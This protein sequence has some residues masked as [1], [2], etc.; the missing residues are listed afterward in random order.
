[1][2]DVR[3]RYGRKG[4]LSSEQSA[5]IE[6][7]EP[8]VIKKMRRLLMEAKDKADHRELVILKP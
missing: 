8:E 1:M 2:S 4:S 5:A 7:L 3:G 6:A